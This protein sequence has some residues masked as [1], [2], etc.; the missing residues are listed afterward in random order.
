MKLTFVILISV[1]SLSCTSGDSDTDASTAPQP[2]N[3]DNVN[4]NVPDTTKGAVLNTPMATD[5]VT[6]RDSLPR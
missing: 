1:L 5:S 2:T 6:G 4:G 3:I